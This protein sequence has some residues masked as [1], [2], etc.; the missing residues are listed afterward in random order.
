[1]QARRIISDRG[2]FIDALH[3]LRRGRVLVSVSDLSG[4]CTLDG[5]PLY[6]AHRTLIDYG[7]VREF[8]NPRGFD[9]VRYYRLSDD[10]RDFAE[11]ACD[12]WRRRP[13]LQRLAVRL[14]G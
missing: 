4:G 14:A 7:L 1:M 10:G 8:D 2:E 11:R 13:L 12:A 3:A 6:S 5:A 9:G